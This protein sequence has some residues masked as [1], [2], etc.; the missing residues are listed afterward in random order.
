MLE[1]FG[2]QAKKRKGKEWER[3]RKRTGGVIFK[4]QSEMVIRNCCGFSMYSCS[5]TRLKKVILNSTGITWK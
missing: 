4:P 5:D 1:T 2:L 3:R